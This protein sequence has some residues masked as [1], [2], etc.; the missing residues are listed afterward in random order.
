MNTKQINW[1][2]FKSCKWWHFKYNLTWF[3]FQIGK[4]KFNNF[5]SLYVLTFY[6]KDSFDE[7]TRLQTFS[8][9][10]LVLFPAVTAVPGPCVFFLLTYTVTLVTRKLMA[11]H[12]SDDDHLVCNCYTHM[13]L[14]CHLLHC[15]FGELVLD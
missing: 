8:H 7:I 5:Y 9:I 4:I 11:G 2:D 6:F 12:G 13:C 1:R 14:L 10:H 15:L 3:L